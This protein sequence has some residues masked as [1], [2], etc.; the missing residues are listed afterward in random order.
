MSVYKADQ[1]ISTMAPLL[2]LSMDT[3]VDVPQN[4]EILKQ[5]VKKQVSYERVVVTIKRPFTKRRLSPESQEEVFH[6]QEDLQT[7]DELFLE[8][9]KLNISVLCLREN[10]PTAALAKALRNSTIP[11]VEF[12]HVNFSGTAPHMQELVDALAHTQ[13][14]YVSI[15]SCNIYSCYYNLLGMNY[16]QGTQ[17]MRDCWPN[18]VRALQGIPTLQRLDW[19][20]YSIHHHDSVELVEQLSVSPKLKQLQIHIHPG[21]HRRPAVVQRMN[22][23]LQSLKSQPNCG[24]TYL[25]FTGVEAWGRGYLDHTTVQHVADVL[26]INQSLNELE[27]PVKHANNAL[28]L[29]QALKTNRTLQRLSVDADF[30]RQNPASQD[31]HDTVVAMLKDNDVLSSLDIRGWTKPK[32][33][34]D[35][36]LLNRAGRAKAQGDQIMQPADW[37]DSLAKCARN[38]AGLYFFLRQN[39]ALLYRCKLPGPSSSKGRGKK[40]KRK[41]SS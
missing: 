35:L 26:L 1:T 20:Q 31:F 41:R 28:P 18:F 37:V 17:L 40:R 27:I 15:D 14:K 2:E 4:I 36:L 11:S 8:L 33:V 30:S 29:I 16:E 5:K 24:L 23:W 19:V 9:G 10:I 21:L 34:K 39:P 13:L 6:E 22:Q 7:W 3:E 32:A 38:M 12:D 25:L